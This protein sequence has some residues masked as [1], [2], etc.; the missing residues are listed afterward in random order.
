ML[1]ESNLSEAV[2]WFETN[3][4][5]LNVDKTQSLLIS[6][7]AGTVRTQDVK[8]LGITIDQNLSWKSH[9]SN[10]CKKLSRVIFLLANLKRQ[11]T[12]KYL[13]MSYFA[14]FESLM[15]Y[16]L[17]VWGNS[18]NIQDILLLQKNA[19]RILTNSG[20]LEH[21]K[22][23]FKETGILTVVN[24]YIFDVLTYVKKNVSS[25]PQR[26]V[27]HNHLTRNRIKIDLP[28]CRL[29]K[30]MNYHRFLGI[31]CYNKLPSAWQFLSYKK[32]ADTLLDW[33]S[34]NPF[35]SIDEYFECEIIS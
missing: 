26:N 16:G 33:L 31:K 11:V 28:R 24:L 2:S 5:F 21:C 13:K 34:K 30:T 19:V 29:S 8:L 10:L 17:I 23:L 25:L 15:R 18:V 14:F 27:I 3:G 1:S 20:C 6:M 4:L 32:F 12:H 7:K 35:Y 9:I 22:P